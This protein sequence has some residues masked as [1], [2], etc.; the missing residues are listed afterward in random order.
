RARQAGVPCHAIV[1]TDAIDRFSAR[2]LDLQ[3]ILEASTR[4][5]LEGAGERL[6]RMLEARQA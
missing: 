6:G 2:I 4:D 5:E 3:V 1:G